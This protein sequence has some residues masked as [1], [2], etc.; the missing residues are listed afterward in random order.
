LVAKAY[1][2]ETIYRAAAF[3]QG[4]DWKTNTGLIA[5]I[6]E[7]GSPRPKR[8]FGDRCT[9]RPSPLAAARTERQRFRLAFTAFTSQVC[10]LRRLHVAPYSRFD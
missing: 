6:W 5:A 2:E 10:R 8:T 7:G 4:P 9:D 3:E 1:D